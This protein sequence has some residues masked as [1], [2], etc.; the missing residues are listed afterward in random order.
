M[1]A[2]TILQP[3][4]AA[5]AYADKRVENRVWPTPPVAEVIVSALVEAVTGEP[6]EVAW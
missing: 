4:A 1:R 6:L 3:W 5:I 2:L